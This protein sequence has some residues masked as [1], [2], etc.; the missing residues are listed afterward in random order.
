MTPHEYIE[1]ARK[2]DNHKV[3]FGETALALGLA[4]EAGEVANEFERGMRIGRG[5]DYSKVYMEIGDVLW[6][7]ARLC[8]ILHWDFEGLMQ[9]NITR[10]TER[11]KN[12][13]IQTR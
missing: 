1:A 12:D 7:I 3:G 13:G 10:L 2:F 9:A 8:D 5:V 11:Y 6:Q 4:A